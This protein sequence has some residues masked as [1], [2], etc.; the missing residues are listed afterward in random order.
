MSA[1]PLAD[2]EARR[3]IREDLGATLV[4]EA[5]AGTGKTTEMIARIIAV[6]RSG[7][8]RLEQ[9]VAV[10]FTEKAAGEMKLRLRTELER[11]RQAAASDDAVR[12]Q[13]ALGELEV[14]RIGSIHSF[15]AD[16]LRQFAVPAGL[17]PRFEVLEEVLAETFRAEA[18]RDTLQSLRVR[19]QHILQRN[20]ASPGMA[21]DDYAT[22]SKRAPHRRHCLDEAWQGPKRGILWM[23]RVA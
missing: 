5:A 13:A 8:S 12:L 7:A 16:L 11:A 1:P 22:Q 18:L 15:C 23:M 10:T 4:V 19:P 9:I 20:G 21:E 6:I 3:A 2:A 14:A 17:D